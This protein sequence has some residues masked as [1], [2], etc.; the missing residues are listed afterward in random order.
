M[1][2]R[3]SIVLLCA[4]LL[5]AK[6]SFAEEDLE[7]AKKEMAAGAKD[8]VAGNCKDALLHFTA[9]GSY[10][11]SAAGPHRELGKTLECLEKYDEAKKEYQLYLS[12]K[13]DAA[14]AQEIRGYIQ[15]VEKKLTEI[16]PEPSTNTPQENG[17]LTFAVDKGAKIFVDDKALDKSQIKNGYSLPSGKYTL[18]VE[19]K[20]FET[21]TKDVEVL[22]GE[23]FAVTESLLPTTTE[24]LKPSGATKSKAPAYV[25]FGIAAAGVGLGVF[26]G[27]EALKLS[28]ELA[29]LEDQPIPKD[30]FDDFLK[31]GL[32]FNI[33]TISGYSVA[34]LGTGL[35][36]LL[37]IRSGKSSGEAEAKKLQVMPSFGGFTAKLSF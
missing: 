26:A 14:D 27:I 25:S 21:L 5:L 31:Q 18:R 2:M 17:K 4:G 28:D 9:A 23:T 12:I 10:A 32:T 22:S 34:A 13:P 33:L 35:G 7:K 6:Q 19:K 37:L 15:D 11:P 24:E 8:F 29:L 1:N 20:G 36:V 16:T 3:I 30:E